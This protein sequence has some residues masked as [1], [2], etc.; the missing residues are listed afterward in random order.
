[1]NFIGIHVTEILILGNACADSV[2]TIEAAI[3]PKVTPE[4]LQRSGA[5]VGEHVNRIFIKITTGQATFSLY[6]LK[7]EKTDWF[8]QK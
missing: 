5:Q 7:K 3:R 6:R 8:Q 1:M 2:L 4:E